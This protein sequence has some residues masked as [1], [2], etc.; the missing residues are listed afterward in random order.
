[1]FHNV[2]EGPFADAARTSPSFLA[3]NSNFADSVSGSTGRDPRLGAIETDGAS[4]REARTAVG[5]AVGTTTRHCEELPDG[6][7]D[8]LAGVPG[9]TAATKCAELEEELP[10]AQ[11]MEAATESDLVA[12]AGK[13]GSNHGGGFGNFLRL[14][15]DLGKPAISSQSKSQMA[16]EGQ[17]PEGGRRPTRHSAAR[18]ARVGPPH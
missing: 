16:T 10:P 12:Q 9:G 2:S 17:G 11:L 8:E 1:M 5:L 7:A 13:T 6:V 4:D 14:L 18:D 3:N 15:E